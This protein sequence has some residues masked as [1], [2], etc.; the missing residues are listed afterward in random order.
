MLSF[1]NN[2]LF[3]YRNLNL[4]SLRGLIQTLTCPKLVLQIKPQCSR[5]KLKKLVSCITIFITSFANK[6]VILTL[7]LYSSGKLVERTMMRKY[8]VENVNN[9]FISFNTICDATQVT[10]CSL[11]PWFCQSGFSL[12]HINIWWCSRT[13]CSLLGCLILF[14]WLCSYFFWIFFL[15]FLFSILNYVLHEL[16]MSVGSRLGICN[17]VCS[18]SD[19]GDLLSSSCYWWWCGFLGLGLHLAFGGMTTLGFFIFRMG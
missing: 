14:H 11:F 10:S 12:N 15:W 7:F 8:G 4:P 19:N 13:L 1:W 2:Y 17:S 5:E 18:H 16:C 9:H 6:I 3:A